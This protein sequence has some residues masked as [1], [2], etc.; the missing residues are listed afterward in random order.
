MPSSQTN[1]SAATPSTQEDKV[2]VQRT[3]ASEDLMS[4]NHLDLLYSG[5]FCGTYILWFNP[6]SAI[7]PMHACILDVISVHGKQA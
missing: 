4:S 7:L 3:W 2:Q 1:I 5:N 6:E